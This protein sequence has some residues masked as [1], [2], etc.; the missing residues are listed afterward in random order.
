MQAVTATQEPRLGR[1]ARLA[2]PQRPAVDKRSQ[3]AETGAPWRVPPARRAARPRPAGPRV[4]QA[5]PAQRTGTQAPA[6]RPVPAAEPHRMPFVLLLCGLL[7]GALVS[8]LVIS[9]TLAAGSFTI[10]K[11]QDSTSVL[12]RQRQAL[13]YQVAQAQSAQVIEERAARL[14]MRR[15]GELLFVNLKTGK[16]TSDGPTWSGAVN[17]PGYAP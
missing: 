7:G 5:E 3:G 16:T 15:T 8:A 13:E 17:A 1:Q 2:P 4:P 9:T 11:L 10:S 12:A 6:P 14:G